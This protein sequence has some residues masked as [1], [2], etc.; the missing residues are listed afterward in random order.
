AIPREWDQDI[1]SVRTTISGYDLP[2]DAS[3][4]LQAERRE[5]IADEIVRFCRKNNAIAVALEEFAFSQG[6]SRA[7]ALGE[8]GGVVKHE[9][10]RNLGITPIPITASRARKILLQRLPRS[11]VKGYVVYNVKRLEGTSLWTNDEVDSFCVANALLMMVGGTCM[12][13]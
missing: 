2:K 3:E 1:A 9:L 7:H 6:Q 12:T 13:F 11:E 8:L 5:R 10:R 4:E